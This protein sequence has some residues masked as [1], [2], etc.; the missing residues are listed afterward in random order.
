[1]V[2]NG[3]EGEPGSV[4]DRYLMMTRAGDVLAGVELAARALRASEAVVYLKGSFA[5]PAAALERARRARPSDGRHDRHPPRRRHVHRGRGDRRPRDPRGAA[6]WPRPKPPLPAAVGFR[7]RPTLVQNVET[8]ALV[9]GRGP[10]SRGVPRLETTLVSLWGH[11]RQ[12]GVYRC[13]S[14]RRCAASSTSTAG[15]PPAAWGLI[16]PAGPSGAPLGPEHAD[17]RLD[18]DA[19]R[20]AGSALGTAAMLVLGEAACPLAVGVS[21]AAFFERESCGQCPPCTAGTANLAR[22]LRALENGGARG[23]ISRTCAKQR[24]SCPTTA[25]APTPGRPRRA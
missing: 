24:A 20:A 11:V 16:L 5:A 10:R 12:P 6:A 13:P 18:P 19:L 8:L 9:P 21:A 15:A 4:K 17:A 7:G 22:V 25:T 14:A 1:V 2:A 3:A 23:R